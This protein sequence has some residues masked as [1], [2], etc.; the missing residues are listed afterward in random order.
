[1]K[2]RLMSDFKK[3][4][5]KENIFTKNIL[6]KNTVNMLKVIFKIFKNVF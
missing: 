3:N 2:K 4:T 1:M 6:S 5:F